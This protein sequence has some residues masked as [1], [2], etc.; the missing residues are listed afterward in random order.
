MPHDRYDTLTRRIT[1]H[2][3]VAKA[4]FGR[5]EEGDESRPSWPPSVPV[6]GVLDS[7]EGGGT[8]MPLAGEALD[9]GHEGADALEAP[10][11][12]RP[13]GKDAD[14]G[15]CGFLWRPVMTEVYPWPRSRAPATWTPA[16]CGGPRNDSGFYFEHI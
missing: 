12:E 7:D 5:S 4:R 14:L 3:V 2:R 13:A 6:R 10:A 1:G 15:R 11:P 9:G 8:G 16:S